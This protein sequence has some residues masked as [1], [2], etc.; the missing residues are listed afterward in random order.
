IRGK[1]FNF[2]ANSA[3][4][5]TQ[6]EKNRQAVHAMIQEAITSEMA[7]KGIT[8]ASG[9][10]DITVA[11]MVVVGN[12]STTVAIND[13]FGYGR[14]SSEIE[15]KIH[16]SQAVDSN[17]PNYFEAG[18]LVIDIVDSQTYKLLKRSYVVKQLLRGQ[19]E[20]LRK[21]NIQQAVNEALK[22]VHIEH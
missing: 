5:A 17:N 21:A 7:A 22:D 11:Y 15:D 19:P 12:N 9:A 6:Y 20:D 3:S 18:T 10:G 1:T 14:D 4:K 16:K 2:V 8:R 13:Y